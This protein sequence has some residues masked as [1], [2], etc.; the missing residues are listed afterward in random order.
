MENQDMENQDMENQDMSW[1]LTEPKFHPEEVAE[2]LGVNRKAVIKLTDE[3][4]IGFYEFGPRTRRI[5]LRH[6]RK[7]FARIQ[8]E[9]ERIGKERQAELRK[10]LRDTA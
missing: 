8:D 2:I 1:M 7:Y 4:M 10:V 5:G 3:G 6:L 9:A